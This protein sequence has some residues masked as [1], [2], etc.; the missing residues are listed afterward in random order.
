MNAG[1]AMDGLRRD[2]ATLN[3]LAWTQALHEAG[4]PLP[5]RTL[6]F[7]DG[8]ARVLRQSA[9][10]A[11]PGAVLTLAPILVFTP[12]VLARWC[13][14]RPDLSPA[15]SARCAVALVSLQLGQDAEQAQ[16]PPAPVVSLIQLNGLAVGMAREAIWRQPMAARLLFGLSG[17][18]AGRLAEAGLCELI[19]L[20][21]APDLLTLRAARCP[22]LWEQVLLAGRVPGAPSARIATE[23][24]LF[25][26][27]AGSPPWPL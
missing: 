17:P 3:R 18:A 24:L 9:L 22:K 25:A 14:A 7:T 11:L 26:L 6:G 13:T 27:C 16:A 21:G 19:G 20:I 15:A 12:S 10:E 23:A 1:P 5:Q 2:I 4:L 8:V